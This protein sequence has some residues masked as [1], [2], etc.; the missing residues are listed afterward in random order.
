MSAFVKGNDVFA[1]LPTDFGKSLCYYC[2]PTIFDAINHCTMPWSIVI[3]ISPLC[4]NSTKLTKTEGLSLTV[5]WVSDLALDGLENNVLRGMAEVTE[6]AG[7]K[8]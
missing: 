7:G 4:K 1:C 8:N 3:V 6:R 5:D 2:L